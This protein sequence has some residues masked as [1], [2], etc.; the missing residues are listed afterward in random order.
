LPP[1]KYAEPAQR[2]AFLEQALA[3]LR[4]LPGVESAGA[5]HRLPLAGNSGTSFEI[6][7]RPIAEGQ[8]RLRAIFRAIS[9]DYFRALGTP[10]VAGRTFTDEEAWRKPTAVI[11]NQ[12]LQ[13]RYW[14]NENPLGKR[15]RHSA[16]NSGWVE[17]I[18]VAADTK[19][20]ELTAEVEGALYL[21]YVVSADPALALVLRTTVEPLSLVAAARAEIRRVDAGQAVSS[22]NTLAGLLREATAQPRFNAALLALFALLA[23]ALA[24]VG[25]YG[26][27]AYAVAQR[28]QEI[29]L[30]LAL[31]ARSGDVLRLILAQGLKLTLSGVGLGLLAAFALTRW[32][33]TLLFGVSAT[34]PLTFVC[35]ALL[36]TCVA[37][38]ACLVPARRAAKVD[39][40][41][42]L[43]HE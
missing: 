23:L 5:T 43:R 28:T 24:G 34:D 39:P 26:V 29:G 21:P 7:G 4:T 33:K 42:A 27:I 31:G 36:L 10:L 9:P 17:I 25:I 22:V 38:L 40:L 41:I 14:P 35:I 18:G 8:P 32:L 1:Q 13:R 3:G 11:I 16:R 6:E 19:E 37:L 2:A 15:L 30:R 20:T 12:T